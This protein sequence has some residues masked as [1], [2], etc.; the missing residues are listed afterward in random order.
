MDEVIVLDSD[1]EQE[2]SSDM[3][4]ETVEL[5]AEQIVPKDNAT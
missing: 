5:D 3:E 1:N 2:Q 4:V